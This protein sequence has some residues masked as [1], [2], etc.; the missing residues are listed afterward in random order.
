VRRTA[1]GLASTP[2]AAL[3]RWRGPWFAGTTNVL[4]PDGSVRLGVAQVCE[5]LATVAGGEGPGE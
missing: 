5:A 1:P 2:D 4:L 3:P